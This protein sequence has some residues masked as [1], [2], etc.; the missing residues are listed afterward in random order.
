MDQ[1]NTIDTVQ[2]RAWIDQLFAALEAA[3]V[4]QVPIYKNQYWSVFHT[5]S[6]DAESPPEPVR[7]NILDDL[8]DLRKELEGS[9]GSALTPWHA[10]H[11]LTGLIS[12]MAY[13]DSQGE[14]R[15]AAESGR[16]P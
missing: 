16:Q 5:D 3:G 15:L 11:H 6:F 13:A 1:V 7:G 4:R 9:K 14:M 10:F 2:L 12:L 8:E